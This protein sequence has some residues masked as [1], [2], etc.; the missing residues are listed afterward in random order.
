MADISKRG[1]KFKIHNWVTR[2]VDVHDALFE[3]TRATVMENVDIVGQAST[4]SD[5]SVIAKL[6]KIVEV[7]GKNFKIL[8]DRLFFFCG[9]REH[10][11]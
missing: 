7:M 4:F 5:E 1:C 6:N 3:M 2:T 10:G 8:K 11:A 9:R